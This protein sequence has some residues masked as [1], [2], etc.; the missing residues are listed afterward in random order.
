MDT[1]HSRHAGLHTVVERL[2]Q[3]EQAVLVATQLLSRSVQLCL[4]TL[5]LFLGRLV[6]QHLEGTVQDHLTL[7]PM[8]VEQPHVFLMHVEVVDEVALEL[9][10]AYDVVLVV[11]HL[12]NEVA[13]LRM[14]LAR[15]NKSE[16]EYT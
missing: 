9:C 12:E 11:F 13:A 6:P 4:R 10:V 14:L 3:Q 15:Q 2:S 1:L 5:L 8:H 16:K 7:L